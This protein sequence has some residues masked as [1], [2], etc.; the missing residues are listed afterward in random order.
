M[1]STYATYQSLTRDMARTTTLVENEPE[2][3]RETEYYLAN[4][5]KVKT[6]DDFV[7]NTRLFTYAMKAFG[8]ED[9]TYAKAFMTKVLTEGVSD[10]DSFANKL[11]DPRYK[12]FAEA[13]NF[14]A[15]KDAAT[16]YVAAQKGVT[17]RYTL[18]AVQNGVS[19]DNPVLK[20]QTDAY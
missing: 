17:D 18:T 5:G 6:V 10:P 3:Q 19:P 20:Q 7:N 15:D 16:T 8:L 4:I 13:F 2:V 9:M 12:A 11:T 14:E 1:T